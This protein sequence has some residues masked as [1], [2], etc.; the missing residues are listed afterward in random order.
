MTSK[1]KPQTRQADSELEVYGEVEIERHV[2]D[3]GRALILYTLRRR[4]DEDETIG[5]GT[6]EHGE[7]PIV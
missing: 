3:D 2:K 7:G 5:N 6:T 1:D 4:A